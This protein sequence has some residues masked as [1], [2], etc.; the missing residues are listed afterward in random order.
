MLA[1]KQEEIWNK[2]NRIARMWW[3]QNHNKIYRIAGNFPSSFDWNFMKILDPISTFCNVYKCSIGSLLMKKSAF[4]VSSTLYKVKF[5]AAHPEQAANKTCL[6]KIIKL[7][8]KKTC[9]KSPHFNFSALT[10][11][12]RQT[13]QQ[14]TFKNLR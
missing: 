3:V 14:S 13:D 1:T 10:F 4:L 5:L 11:T 2:L 9:E 7:E 12:I 8:N 6:K